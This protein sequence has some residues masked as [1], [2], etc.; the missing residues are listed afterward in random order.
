MEMIAEIWEKDSVE[1]DMQSRTV[2]G[3]TVE[4]IFARCPLLGSA[5]LSNKSIDALG[6]NSKKWVDKIVEDP[7]IEFRIPPKAKMQITLAVISYAKEWDASDET[8]FWRYIAK[9]FGYRDEN[10]RIREFLY[11]CIRDALLS[12]QR[13][14]LSNSGGNMYKATIVMHAFSTKRSW[15][16]FCDLLFDFYK[17]NLNW[18]Y[19]D[20][21]PLFAWMVIAMRNKLMNTA[22][23][24]DNGIKIS[25]KVYNFR[26]GIHKLIL[27]RPRYATKLVAK[28]VKR[29]DAII[30]HTA[31]APTCY[32]DQLC[33]EWMEEKIRRGSISAGKEK[34]PAHHAVAIDYTRIHPAY[35]LVDNSRVK[36]VFPDVRMAENDFRALRL[37]VYHED[38]LVEERGLEYYGDELG[39][40]MMGFE[41][42]LEDYLRKSS[43]SRISPRIVIRCDEKE[44]YNSETTLYRDYLAFKGKSEIAAD[45]MVQGN[46]SVFLPAAISEEYIQAEVSQIVENSY[47]KGSFIKLKKDFAVCINNQM[48]AVDAGSAETAGARVVAPSAETD[49]CYIREGVR[50]RIVSGKDPVHIIVSGGD[51]AKKQYRLSVN[52]Q[53]LDLSTLPCDAKDGVRIYS[54]GFDSFHTD[55]LSLRLIDLSSD[56]LMEQVHL[57]LSHGL[58][59]RFN[60]PYYAMD[61]DYEEASVLI[62]DD[63]GFET[64][65]QVTTEDAAIEV[66]YGNGELMLP[67]PVVRFFDNANNVWDGTICCWIKDLPQE[68]LLFMKAP[69][70]LST[71]VLL[72]GQPVGKPTDDGYAL[73]NAVFGYSNTLKKAWLDVHARITANGEERIL[74][75]GRI[76][77]KEQFL[78]H[79]T[80]YTDGDSLRWDRGHGFIGNL[81]AKLELCICR[82]TPYERSLILDLDEETILEHVDLP[83]G[84]YSFSIQKQSENL[85]SVT[86]E[87]LE[88]GNFCVGD[89]NELRFLNKK[90]Q[91]DAI[92]P[93]SSETIASVKID[94]CYVEDIRYCGIKPIPAENSNCPVYTGT[95]VLPLANGR[96]YTYSNEER[97]NKRGQQ[98]YKVNPV[99]IIY[100]NPHALSI[101]NE[102]DDGL[103]YMKYYKEIDAHAKRA[104][105]VITDREPP[106][107]TDK[108]YNADLYLYTRRVID[109]V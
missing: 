41:L 45:E 98:L 64:T 28:M 31:G 66:P 96:K 63:D 17:S 100:L 23:A 16:Q 53:M 68:R 49:A 3:D 25:S 15:M 34:R 65:C 102:D 47:I 99:K 97:V 8:G 51:A 105:Y 87:D 69:K 85:F 26:E 14:F 73:G 46:Y 13:V 91:I 30:N 103:Y 40:T 29:I 57:R 39:R 109:D 42:S 21:D 88:T 18:E 11:N 38:S 36:L 9:Q 101:T 33:D 5:L 6:A 86:K 108:W 75:L 90:I 78:T 82:D 24:D 27:F 37:S 62:S 48:V 76:A 32:E 67:V 12:N 70:H 20:G 104:T 89:E 22:D 84:E 52:Q 2:D 10:D 80:L 60:K 54:L 95:L 79:P 7:G 61:E 4:K 50:Y 59:Y 55:E 56:R 81:R 77:A 44:I 71:V 74:R 107:G 1:R 106:K 19:I 58:F 92:T 72:D 93:W 35:Q 83:I 43:A 94:R